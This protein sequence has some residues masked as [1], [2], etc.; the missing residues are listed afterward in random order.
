MPCLNRISYILL[1]H[2]LFLP[3]ILI[4]FL[5]G[6]YDTDI[7]FMPIVVYSSNQPYLI[8]T[9]VE[10]GEFTH[11]IRCRKHGAH[12]RQGSKIAL[13][14]VAVPVLKSCS[15][16]RVVTCKIVQT[17]SCNDVHTKWC[18]AYA[19]IATPL[20]RCGYTPGRT[21]CRVSDLPAGCF[22]E[23]GA[24]PRCWCGSR[25]ADSSI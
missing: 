2:H 4:I 11:F 12:F 5:M 21:T 1:K 10:D 24:L 6:Q 19:V 16:V 9:N 13:L 3:S 18:F 8:T 17:L 20:L 22:Q 14:H 23:Y 7:H 15:G 25:D